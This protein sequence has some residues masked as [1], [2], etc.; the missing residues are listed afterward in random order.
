MMNEEQ[1]KEIAVF[2]FGVIHEF[3]SGVN[4]DRGER[5]RLLTEKCGRQWKIPFSEKS[6]ISRSTLLRWIR[7][8]HEGNAKLEALYPRERSDRGATRAI[9]E[10]TGLCLIGLRKELP[11]A[12]VSHLIQEMEWR[13][14]VCGGITLHP[15]TVYR[16][17]H[18]HNL[19][20]K[21]AH[22]PEDRRKFEAEVPNDLW[23]YA[24]SRI[25]RH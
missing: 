11:R 13:G 8:Y 24:A 15:S 12:T 19:M 16:F 4:L 2:R 5:E 14:W 9:D 21:E 6:R 18:Q 23:H 3:V 17:L 7:L 25:I 22:T 10:E 1:K 20:A